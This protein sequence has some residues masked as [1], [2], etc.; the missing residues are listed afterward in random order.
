MIEK[1][2]RSCGTGLSEFLDLT[3][4]SKLM[5][6]VSFLIPKFAWDASIEDRQTSESGN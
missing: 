4:T 2:A 5:I 1:F 3:H 6:L